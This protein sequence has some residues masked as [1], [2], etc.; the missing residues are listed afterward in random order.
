MYLP[1][2]FSEPR[3]E[4]LCQLIH[5]HPLA[6]LVMGEDGGLDADHLPLM[7]ENLGDG[8]GVLRGHVARANPLW[9]RSGAPALAIFHGPE[10]Y[11][12]PGWY[13]SKVES[14]RVVP[15]WNYAVVHARG[16]LSAVEDPD[17]LRRHLDALTRR[18][19]AAMPHPWRLDE[20]PADFIEK[21]AGA[22]VGIEIVLDSLDGKYKLSQN[23]SP[24]DRDGVI[25]GL[26]GRGPGA[27]GLAEFMACQPAP[28]STRK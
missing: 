6:A 14:G 11:V 22:I 2:V 26:R 1:E 7:L 8:L 23:R 21:L 15:T 17:W 12:S 10:A 18:R 24:A 13:P 19:E 28:P 25:A 27:A 3:P 16:R 5:A 9:R 4:V 20:A